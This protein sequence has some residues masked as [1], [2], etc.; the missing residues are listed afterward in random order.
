MAKWNFYHYE[1][2]EYIIDYEDGMFTISFEAAY[3]WVTPVEEFEKLVLQ[4]AFEKLSPKAR[5]SAAEAFYADRKINDFFWVGK[6]AFVICGKYFEID[7]WSQIRIFGNTVVSLYEISFGDNMKAKAE[8]EKRLK[9]NRDQER[10]EEAYE[11]WEATWIS[12]PQ[13]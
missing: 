8:V 11:E 7:I 3:D 2:D 1:H 6:D 13:W 4:E 9:S 5:A 12:G 10:W